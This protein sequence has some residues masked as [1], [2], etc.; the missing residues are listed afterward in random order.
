MTHE[1]FDRLVYKTTLES[2]LVK[3]PVSGAGPRHVHTTA[4]WGRELH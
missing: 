4:E 3:T 1:K 2:S